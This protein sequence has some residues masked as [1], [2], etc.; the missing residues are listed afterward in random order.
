MNY[1]TNS[2]QG[3]EPA[4]IRRDIKQVFSL[5]KKPLSEVEAAISAQAREFDP[6][7]EPYISYACESSGKRIRPALVLLSGSAL[8]P[9]GEEHTRLAVILEL[10]HLATLVHDDIMDGAE[11]RRDQATANARWGNATSVLL[12]DCLFAHALG[13][14]TT[15]ADSEICR[16]VA[17]ASK[18]VCSGEIIQTQ[19]RFDLKLKTAD[20][21]R[22][23]EMKTAALFSVAT[24]LGARLSGGDASVIESMKAYGT[25]MGTAYQIY[26]D[27]LDIVGNEDEAGKS[28]RTDLIKGKLTL[29]LLNLLESA[30]TRKERISQ[31]I[32]N[33]GEPEFIELTRMVQAE[34][35]LHSALDT[36]RKMVAEAQRHVEV[37]P[38]NR[39]SEA[40]VDV[41]NVLISFLNGLES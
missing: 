26:D 7:V 13:L 4:Q 39:H 20:Y 15:F 25:K 14:A 35:A 28:L 27:C 17:L 19:R 33:G 37:L 5:I 29:P 40:L 34:G 41:G 9:V 11:L 6:A 38:V 22:I 3:I 31:M 30:G 10:I 12:G 8:G 24:E 21:Y 18:E 23:I 2:Q 32:L 1:F 16:R 36:G